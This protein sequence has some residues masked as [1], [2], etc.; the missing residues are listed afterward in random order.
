MSR[1]DETP[2]RQEERTERST[3]ALLDAAGEIVAE[4]GFASMTFAT[5]GERA[6]YSR[7]LVTARFGNKNG[8]IEA[9][10][11]RLLDRWTIEGLVPAAITTTG[12]DAILGRLREIRSNFTSELPEIHVFYALMFEAGSEP[13]VRARFAELHAWM[14]RDVGATIAAGRDDGSIDPAVDPDTEATLLIAAVRGIGFQW[15]LDPN[16]FDPAP[17]I[18]HLIATT[19]ERLSPP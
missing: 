17:A 19:T 6:G 2:Q 14:R 4:G 12:F 3:S 13:A 9:M 15:R 1:S 5:I 10:C 16:G 7:G 8:L 18:D 11:D